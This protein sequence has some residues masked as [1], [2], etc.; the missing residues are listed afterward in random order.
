[1]TQ[2]QRQTDAN[3]NLNICW[4]RLMVVCPYLKYEFKLTEQDEEH[5]DFECFTTP[6]VTLIMPKK[7]Q[8]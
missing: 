3:K 8:E 2:E 5:I 6:R 1:M 7:E 4:Q